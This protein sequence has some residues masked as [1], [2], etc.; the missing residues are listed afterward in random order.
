M[1]NRKTMTQT[2]KSSMLLIMQAEYVI[3]MGI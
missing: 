2:N 3:I 1:K